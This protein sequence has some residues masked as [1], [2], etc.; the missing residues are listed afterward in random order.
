[1][2]R[3]TAFQRHRVHTL[4][5]QAVLQRRAGAAISFS[6]SKPISDAV[7]GVGHL[8]RL[9]RAEDLADEAGDDAGGLRG[10]PGDRRRIVA[11]SG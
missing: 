9:H 3:L 5:E 6:S 2:P 1:M 8:D 11:A 10:W 4:V 7:L